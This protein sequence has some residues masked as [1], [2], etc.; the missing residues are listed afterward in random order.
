[1]KNI[2]LEIADNEELPV[3]CSNKSLKF[4]D[5]FFPNTTLNQ[6]NNWKWQIQN[7]ITSYEKLSEIFGSLN[8][9]QTDNLNLPLRITP[10]YASNISVINSGIGKCMIPSEHE[11][12]FSDNEEFDAL[13]EENQSPVKN[14]VHRYPDRVLFLT[15]SFCSSYC[16][17]CTRSRLVGQRKINKKDWNE[18]INYIKNHSEI[19]DVLLSGGDFL[20]LSDNNI[21]Y[22]LSQIRSIEHVE[23]IRIGT[24]IPIVLP[25][26]I[27]KNLL[28]ILKK[29]H[30]LLISIHVTH[31][32]EL[33]PEVKYACESLA[34]CGIPLG[35]QTVLLKGINDDA[36]VMK[37]LMHQLIKIRIKP[38]YLYQC[39]Q[40]KGSSH[41]RTNL[42]K[43]IEIID[44]LR[45]HTTGY[46]IPKFIVDS[47]LGKIEISS[48]NI[49]S[50][51]NNVHNLKTYKGNILQY[52]Q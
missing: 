20:S 4:K 43:G 9:K 32:D 19:R 31:P 46:C 5:K 50:I 6:W 28:N 41:F 37:K 3:I 10:Y 39:D 34:N 2:T 18:G 33:T 13:H 51:E 45:G 22:L 12:I 23:I 38:Y 25:Q 7:S 36:E 42:N 16:R 47:H 21:K 24:K 17:Y 27:T 14:I 48:N 30:P 49:V 8:Y 52:K 1:M 40:I 44:S 29:Y 11:L 15:T 26:R 35:S